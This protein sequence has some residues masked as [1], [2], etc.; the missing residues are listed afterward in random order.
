MKINNVQGKVCAS[1]LLLLSCPLF[2][3]EFG[4]SVSVLTGKS[5]NALKANADKIDERQDEYQLNLKGDYTNSLLHFEGGYGATDFHFSKDSQENEKFLEG[6]ASLL[7]G[8]AYDPAELLITHTRKTLLSSPDK[9][10]LT[11]NQDERDIL[12]VSPTLRA[13]ISKSDKL[14]VSGIATRISYLENEILDSSRSGVTVGW[15]HGISSIQSF[16]FTAQQ[17]DV[18]FD[19]FVGSDYKYKNATLIYATQ[20]RNLSYSLQLGHN[21]SEP[22]LG[23]EYSSPTYGITLGYKNGLHEI[24]LDSTQMITDSSQGGGNSDSINESPNSDGGRPEQVDQIERLNTELRWSTFVLCENCNIS[25]SVYQRDEDYLSLD[26]SA[27]SRGASAGFNYRFSKAATFSLNTSKNRAGYTGAAIGR[28]YNL[29]LSAIEYAYKFIN[30]IGLKLFVQQEKRTSDL[31]DQRYKENYF[32]GGL[33][34]TF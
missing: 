1:L 25:I 15:A 5:D 20:L 32:G 21:K 7:F 28:D 3:N 8:K 33:D 31:I 10:A 6:D 22:E 30:G 9:V 14:F 4:G 34:Y 27:K 26:Q 29:R 19:N 16:R 23:E 13:K 24:T 11:N 17:T 12:T 2:A 18:E